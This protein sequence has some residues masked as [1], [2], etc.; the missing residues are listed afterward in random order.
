MQL[1]S[2]IAVISYYVSMQC[3]VKLSLCLNFIL[4][5]FYLFLIKYS[6]MHIKIVFY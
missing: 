5:L 2:Q 6:S 4:L 3:I 1:E